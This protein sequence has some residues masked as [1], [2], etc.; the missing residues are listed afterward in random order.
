MAYTIGL[1][2]ITATVAKLNLLSCNK[3]TGLSYTS[4]RAPSKYIVHVGSGINA[5]DM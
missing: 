3:H 2:I 1:I 5:I 4:I